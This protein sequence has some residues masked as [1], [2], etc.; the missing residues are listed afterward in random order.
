MCPGEK[1]TPYCCESRGYNKW[2]DDVFS[3]TVRRL[4]SGCASV[5]KR[6]EC[7]W[8]LMKIRSAQCWWHVPVQWVPAST[9]ASRDMLN[10]SLITPSWTIISCFPQRVIRHQQHR[11]V[12]ADWSIMPK[13]LLLPV[14]INR[15]LRAIHLQPINSVWQRSGY[16][17][18]V[19]TCRM[20][21][22][23]S[24]WKLAN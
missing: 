12:C 16:F 3:Q 23:S 21:H 17:S 15:A 7:A 22:H 11:T 20:S 8:L 2:E 14:L 10:C 24:V 1:D 6:M 4:E 13:N 19:I 9:G 5:G 18:A